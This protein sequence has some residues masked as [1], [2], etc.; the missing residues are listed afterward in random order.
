MNFIWRSYEVHKKFLCSS[1]KF[2]SPEG[3][4]LWHP[5]N[6]PVTTTNHLLPHLANYLGHQRVSVFVLNIIVPSIH[7]TDKTMRILLQFEQKSN[8][9][10]EYI[11]KMQYKLNVKRFSTLNISQV[12][13]VRTDSNLCRKE[14]TRLTPLSGLISSLVQTQCRGMKVKRWLPLSYYT[15]LWM[16]EKRKFSFQIFS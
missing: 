9:I 1:N 10:M 2:Q 7:L 4:E 5:H 8:P 13:L 12:I 11:R 15:R 14:L 3:Y 6:W 16:P